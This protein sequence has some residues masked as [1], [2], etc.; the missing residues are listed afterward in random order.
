MT[1]RSK[2]SFQ[3]KVSFRPSLAFVMLVLFMGVLWLAG[4]ASRGEVPGQIVVRTAA[5]L[6]LIVMAVFG[7]RVD[8][9]FARPAWIFLAVAIAIAVLQLLPLPPALWHMLPGRE[10]VAKAGGADAAQVC[11]SWSLVPSETLNALASLVVPFVVL[12]LAA[13][14]TQKERAW[15]PGMLLL[16][17]IASMLLGIFQ[18]SGALADNPLINDTPG[19]VSATFANRNHFALFLALGCLLVPVWTFR[20]G[21]QLRW[22]GPAGLGMMALFTLTILACGSRAGMALGA[23]AILIAGLI[24][25]HG[26]RREFRRAPRWVPPV[27]VG[28]I[29][30]LFASLVL[31]S[32][33]ADRAVSV[34]RSFS[35]DVGQDMRSRA[36]PTVLDMTR[37][38]F[39]AGSGMGSF[40]AMFRIHEPL[41]LLKPTYFNHAHNDFIEIVLDAGLP[42]LLILLAALIWWGWASMRAWRRAGKNGTGKS[43]IGT[44]G[45]MLPMLGS[46]TL[47]L[48]LIASIFDYPARTPMIMAMVVLAAAW[49]SG[50]SDDDMEPALPKADHHL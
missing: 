11:Q 48:V 19:A 38:V 16:F 22:R 10:I 31:I 50:H 35:L 2:A 18:F 8:G 29:I 24:A 49:L 41:A 13:G 23:L 45:A 14:L 7:R 30:A 12:L 6:I 37:S 40:D 36:L 26:L 4:G 33:V 15:L 46:A 42:G 32:V 21:R 44:S 43:D 28:G 25:R 34:Q 47:L 39:P 5:W 3:A 9:S 20:E 27:V 17:V 1:S